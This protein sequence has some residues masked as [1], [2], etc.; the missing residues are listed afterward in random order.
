VTGSSHTGLENPADPN[1]KALE[2]VCEDL[3]GYKNRNGAIWGRGAVDMKHMAAQSLVC[4]LGLKRGK[5]KLKRDVI[6]AGVADEEAGGLCGAGYL[7]DHRPELIR[8]EFCM[9]E[10][11]GI[12]TP[13]EDAIIVPVQTAQKI[14]LYGTARGVLSA[15]VRLGI[16]GGYE[17]QR[18]LHLCEPWLDRVAETCAELSVSDLAQTSPVIDL[19]QSRH[20]RLYSRLFQS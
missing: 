3:T 11:G 17:A 10:V 1:S 18:M 12:A 5:V 20:D 16:A 6:F 9:T 14:V 13:I 19:L 15:A 7:V 2:S 4:L 8:S